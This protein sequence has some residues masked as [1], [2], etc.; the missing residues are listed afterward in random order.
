M[1]KSLFICG[2]MGAGKS[3]FGKR[4]ADTMGFTFVDLDDHIEENEKTSISEIFTQKGEAFFRVLELS[5]ITSFLEKKEPYIIALGGGAVCF[6]DIDKMLQENSNLVYLKSDPEKIYNRIQHENHRP[7]L[8]GK[9]KSEVLAT[10]TELL[11]KRSENYNKAHLIVD[12][13]MTSNTEVIKQIR[14]FY[15][16]RIR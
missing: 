14:E 8:N 7:L 9:S 6:N 2:L 11:E 1:S 4:I 5:G 15:E 10:L 3:Y 13:D 16:Q 12:V